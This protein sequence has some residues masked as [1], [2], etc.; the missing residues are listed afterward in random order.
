M[1][2]NNNTIFFLSSDFTH[3]VK[4]LVDYCTILRTNSIA[5]VCLLI[6]VATCILHISC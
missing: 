5:F 6:H 3:L 1:L 2:I 4:Q